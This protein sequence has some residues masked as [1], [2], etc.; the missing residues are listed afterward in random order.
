MINSQAVFCYLDHNYYNSVAIHLVD[1]KKLIH[2]MTITSA[3]GTG[4]VPHLTVKVQSNV[5]ENSWGLCLSKISG[6]L[7]HKCCK[8]L[9]IFEES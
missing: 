4:P 3:M 7:I 8:A 5:H 2:W 1:D 6:T 9:H